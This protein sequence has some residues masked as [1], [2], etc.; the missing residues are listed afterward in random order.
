MMKRITNGGGLTFALT[1]LLVAG[2]AC[3]DFESPDDPTGG[4]PDLLYDEPSFN[5]HVAPIFEA[6]CA[7]GGCHSPAAQQQGLVLEPSVAYDE[8]VGVTSQLG[9]GMLLVV[10]GEPDDSWLMRMISPDPAGRNGLSRMPLA[11]TP[12]TENQIENIRRWI[13]QGAARN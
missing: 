10:P 2:T 7:T 1:L 6:R 8:I 9:Q 13:E 5:G 12:L 4:L 3:A 11:S